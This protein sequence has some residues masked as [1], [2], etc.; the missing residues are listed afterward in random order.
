[1]S[2]QERLAIE[3]KVREAGLVSESIEEVRA[4][5]EKMGRI[6]PLADGVAVEQGSIAGRPVEYLRPTDDRGGVVLFFHGGGY[7]IGSLDSH[8]GLA[9]RLAVASAATVIAV[10]YR[11]APESFFPGA[12]D[13]CLSV[14][15]ALV[16]DPGTAGAITLAGDSAG[17]ALVVATLMAAR[18]EGV[19]LPAAA[20]LMSP[21]LDLTGSGDSVSQKADVDVVVRPGMI[22]GMGGGY[23][24][25]APATDPRASPLF[26][27][28]GGLPPL[29]V[30]VGTYES[31]LDDSLRLVRKVAIA[32]GSVELKV[33]PKMPHVFQL[34]AGE[35]EE[36]RLSLDEAGAFLRSHLG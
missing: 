6:T 19:A 35:L 15:R 13:D 20:F 3:A 28:V 11:L 12:S 7:M 36:G 8:R 17:G 16:Q 2:D 21:F 24:N 18:D 4:N 14:Y 5:Y 30:H 29:L 34:F 1:M 31:I 10:D 32:D 33:W 25:G 23:L 27:N 9:S 26:G 22:E